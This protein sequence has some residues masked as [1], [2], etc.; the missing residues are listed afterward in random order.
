M[1]FGLTA[2]LETSKERL[3]SFIVTMG[4]ERLPM[5]RL[6]RTLGNT[7]ARAWDWL[8]PTTTTTDIWTYLSRM[9]LLLTFCCTTTGMGPSKT[10]RWRRGW[11]TRRM[12]APLPAWALSSET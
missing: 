4:M 11:H 6:R 7:S 10:W 9:T 12:E 3:T 5:F 8:L 2:L 1:A